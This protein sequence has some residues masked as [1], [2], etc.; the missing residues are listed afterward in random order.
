[1]YF[2]SSAFQESQ[3]PQE[4]TMSALALDEPSMLNGRDVMV[5]AV[6]AVV[7]LPNVGTVC[8]FICK[9]LLAKQ[10]ST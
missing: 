5:C 7:Y 4:N 8:H 1:M 10:S 9:A 2:Q 3:V 6:V